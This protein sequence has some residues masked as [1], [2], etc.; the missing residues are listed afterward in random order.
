MSPYSQRICKLLALF[1]FG[2]LAVGGMLRA[3]V[4]GF[5]KESL[6]SPNAASVAEVIPSSAG[7]IVILAGG[8]EQGLQLGM[9]CRVARGFQQVGELIIIESRSDRAAALILELSENSIIQAG[10]VARIKTLQNS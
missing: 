6:H 4:P 5:V 3:E 8:L 2:A 1:L 10:D 9:V 7:D